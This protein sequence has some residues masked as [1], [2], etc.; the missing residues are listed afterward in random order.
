MN[1]RLQENVPLAPLTSF[2]IG[3]P[4]R[5]FVEVSTEDEILEAVSYAQENNLE[6]FVLAGGSN[7][8]V[9]D[10]GF[11]GLVIRIRNTKYKIQDTFL[12]GGAGLSLYSVVRE[13]KE[14]SLTGL[15]WATGIPGSIGGAVRGNAGAYGSEIK[16][17]IIS[18]KALEINGSQNTNKITNL[19]SKIF[20]NEECEFSYRDSIFKRNNNLMILDCVLKLQKGDPVEIKDKMKEIIRKRIE[21]I[22]KEPSPGSFFKNPETDNKELIRRFEIDT[23]KKVTDHVSSYQYV[24]NRIKIPAP[25]L[26]EEAGLKGKIIGG[27]MVSEKHAN[28][29]VN[30][31]SGKAQDVIMLAS[32]IKMKVRNLWGIQ[33]RE[34]IQYVGF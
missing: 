21:K 31:G 25:W 18:V 16:D 33:L 14:N 13:A 11:N 17:N 32:L 10:E 15:E 4:A 29:V 20:T 26:I 27:V 1:I 30:L 7:I 23:G 9:S 2:K 12:E 3:G 28:F 22:P 8:L 24:D 19:K 5:Y 6:I 34:E